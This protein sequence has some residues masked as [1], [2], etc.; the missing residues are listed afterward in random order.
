MVAY[1]F[2][3][4]FADQVSSL[5]KRQTVRS[6]RKRHGRPGEP[7]QLYQ[8]MRT[9]ACRKLV[10]PDPVCTFVHKIEISLSVLIDDMIASISIDGIPLR[11]EEIEAFAQADGFDVDAVGDWR[12]KA[13]GRRGSAR[14]NMG[15]FWMRHHGS[16]RFDGVLVKWEPAI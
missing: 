1:S 12:F 13:T 3:A 7:L 10:D 6:E 2:N 15:D 11:P 8:G 9:R 5:R 16:G 4:I 14:W